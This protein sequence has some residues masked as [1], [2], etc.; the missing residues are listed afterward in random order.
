MKSKTT[1]S[2]VSQD[3][4]ATKYEMRSKEKSAKRR[5]EGRTQAF[6]LSSSLDFYTHFNE[7]W[8]SFKM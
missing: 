4:D 1:T 8:K 3:L 6:A 7:A 2:T 5:E